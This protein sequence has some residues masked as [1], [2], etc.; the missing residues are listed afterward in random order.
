M[1]YYYA[2]SGHKVGLDRVKRAAAL[3]KI[4]TK[5]GMETRLLVNDFRAGL[6]AKDFG[7]RE[8]VTIET[9][10]DIDAIAELGDSI[11][12]DSPENDRGR[13]EKYCS[14][15]HKVFRFA[16]SS[17]DVS[18]YGEILLR[19]PCQDEHCLSSLIVDD[20]YLKQREKKE[21]V[22]MFF[23][24][25]DHDKVLLNHLHLFENKNIELLLGHYFF[26]KYEDALDK[27]FSVLHESEEYMEVISESKYVITSSFQT[28][29]EAKA[30]GA[31]TLFLSLQESSQEEREIMKYFGILISDTIDISC[32]RNDEIS[33]HT[34]A[35]ENQTTETS[36]GIIR[37]ILS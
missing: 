29:L 10:Q 16:N 28:A 12:I 36:K 14:G 1:L 24:D 11:I 7:I 33:T 20:F 3:L 19:Y 34:I 27:T 31:T 21:R 9:V 18:R 30:S 23:G 22:V 6:A 15:F 35:T 2:H 4:L 17:N 8:S 13:L 5:E 26:V 32:L 37:E 25:S